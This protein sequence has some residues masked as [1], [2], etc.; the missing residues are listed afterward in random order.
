MLN[1]YKANNTLYI[2][3]AL[4]RN[5]QAE[6][7]TLTADVHNNFNSKNA[8]YFATLAANATPAQLQQAIAK[9]QTAS[10]TAKVSVNSSSAVSKQL[11]KNTQ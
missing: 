9:L 6:F 1:T 5:L 3:L 11:A 10:N 4:K 2:K 8:L 7:F